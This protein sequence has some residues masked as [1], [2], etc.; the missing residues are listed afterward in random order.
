MDISMIGIPD[1]QEIKNILGRK[2]G[3]LKHHTILYRKLLD[4]SGC[5]KSNIELE[6]KFTGWCNLQFQIKPF[7]SLMYL[8]FIRCKVSPSQKT[9]IAIT[10]YLEDNHHIYNADIRESDFY[11]RFSTPL[12]ALKWVISYRAT[13]LYFI[14]NLKRDY[15]K[16]TSIDIQV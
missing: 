8:Y 14:R 1:E 9:M 2:E 16:S 10:K 5:T 4:F 7:N 11:S 12:D 6:D 3:I 13:R 15:E